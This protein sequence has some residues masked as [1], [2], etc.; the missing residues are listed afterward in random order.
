MEESVQRIEP[1]RLVDVPETISDAVAELSA[2]SATLGNSLHPL[3]AANLADL[4]RLMNTYYSNL[5]EG[6]DTRPR[7][8]ERALAGNFEKNEERRNLQIE[9]AAHVRLQAEIDRLAAR[10][11]LPEPAS[12]DFILWLHQEF[13]RDAE[14]PALR[15]KGMGREFLMTPGEWRSSPEHDVAVGRHQ[16]PSSTRVGDFMRHFETRYRFARLGKAGRILAIPAAHHRFNFIH[17]FPDGN[18]RVSRLMSHAMAHEAGIAAHGLWSI[19]RGLARGLESRNDYKA[20]MDHADMPRQGD[21]DG[22]GNLSQRALEEFT[23]WFL[24]IC[25]DQVSFMSGL[26]DLT[27]LAKRLRAYVGRQEIKPE[28]G[29]LLEEALMRG[30]FERGEISRITGLPERTARRVFN[31]VSSLGLLASQTPKGPVSLR[32]PVD[33]LDMLFPR[34]FPET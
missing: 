6:H 4:V 13:Y 21:L 2:A 1:A 14:E 15:I 5:I 22:R 28:A 3:T 32:F 34:L 27:T 30:E 8:I 16:P 29:R 25:I 10:S 17:P 12:C 7:D 26:L 9:A 24:R 18:G 23:L 11:E 33:A 31:D 20:M 19:S